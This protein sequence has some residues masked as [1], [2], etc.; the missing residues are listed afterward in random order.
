MVLTVLDQPRRSSCDIR[1]DNMSLRFITQNTAFCELPVFCLQCNVSV[2]GELVLL[3]RV[4]H[5][6]HSFSSPRHHQFSFLLALDS[7]NFLFIR[8]LGP[9]SA[10][11]LSI[12]HY[13][14][15]SD[16]ASLCLA[17]HPSHLSSV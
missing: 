15:P 5:V 2:L 6:Q 10:R 8:F 17:L 4:L 7:S 11:W 14:A 1:E 16:P 9:H 13:L 3:G 12:T